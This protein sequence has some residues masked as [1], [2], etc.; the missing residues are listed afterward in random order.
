M[1]K[2]LFQKS[3]HFYAGTHS[4]SLRARAQTALNNGIPLFVTEWGTV[5]ANGDGAVDNNSTDEWMSFLAENDISHLNWS[6]HDKDEGA[7]ILRP[8]APSNGNWSDNDLTESGLKVRS[9]IET[10]D[11]YCNGAPINIEEEESS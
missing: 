11:Q 1:L 8:G 2:L 5:N 6:V 7:S 3:L 4:A 9:I 10:W